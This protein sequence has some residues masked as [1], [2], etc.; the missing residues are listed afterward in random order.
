MSPHCS[1]FTS[2]FDAIIKDLYALIHIRALTFSHLM[3]RIILP[4]LMNVISPFTDCTAM[5]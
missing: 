3:V 4:P 1:T 2:S 5:H